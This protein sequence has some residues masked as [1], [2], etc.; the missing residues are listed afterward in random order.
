MRL[1]KFITACVYILLYHNCVYGSLVFSSVQNNYDLSDIKA[2]LTNTEI[3]KIQFHVM[4]DGSTPYSFVRHGFMVKRKDALG[5]V[6]ICHGYLGCKQDAIALRHLFPQYNIVAFDFRA[7]G[8]ARHGQFSTIGRD[9]AYDVIG[10]VDFI[11]S[12]ADL[13]DKPIIAFGYSMGAVAAIQAQ[14][15]DPTLF[16]AMILDCPFD[17]TDA[18]MSR[19]LDTKLQFSLFGKT[20]TLPL[21]GLILKYMYTDFAQM[22]TEYLFQKITAFDSKRVATKFVKVTP[23]ESIKKITV[24]C[25]FI[26]CQNDNKVPVEAV[27]ALYDAKPGFKRLWITQGKKHFGSYSNDPEL[28]W[29]KVNKFLTK[30]REQDLTTREQAKVCDQRTKNML[31]SL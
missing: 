21:K 28:Y 26:H 24:P 1:Q 11:R 5:T 18:A 12:E 22:V 8:D 14:S 27:Q 7:H 6:L 15:I 17:S 16:S 9:E 23:L 3:Q 29:Y 30:L 13:Q 10:A 4:L 20:I 31:P 19:G 25:L 2:Q